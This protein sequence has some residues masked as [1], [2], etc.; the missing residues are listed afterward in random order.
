MVR[1]ETASMPSYGTVESATRRE[2]REG[3]SL[4]AVVRA[5]LSVPPVRPPSRCGAAVSPHAMNGCVL[6]VWG[7]GARHK[8][9]LGS[10]RYAP[11]VS[12]TL[13]LCLCP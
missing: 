3:F 9:E 12:A 7:V 6:N 13:A 1:A 8:Q 5:V 4:R 11:C 10:G 2:T